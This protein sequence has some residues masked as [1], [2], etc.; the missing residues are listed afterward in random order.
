VKEPFE[1]ELKFFDPGPLLFS[2]LHLAANERL[3][4]TFIEGKSTAL[5]FESVRIDNEF[6]I[7]MPMSEIAGRM[8]VII[9]ANLLSIKTGGCGLLLG[10]AMGI[11]HG[12]VVILGGGTAGKNAALAGNGLGAHVI[13]LE[14]D[15]SK[16]KYLN[17]VL[18]KGISI[19]K[20]NSQNL[21]NCVK[22]ANILIGTVLI[23]NARAP[24]LVSREMVRTMTP[25]SVIVDI[26]IDQG[27]CIETSRPT[28]HDNPTFI[29][30]EIIHYCVTNMPGAYPQT[31]TEAL[32]ENL[33]PFLLNLISEEDLLISLKKND[34]LK[35]SVNVFKGN[36]AIKTIADEFDIEY[37]PIDELL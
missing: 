31:S 11:Y 18:P 29:D 5:A 20:S 36:V 12:Y 26:S 23:P 1:E 25:G 3:I 35:N 15:I 21:R 24:R 7:L 9:G 16:I 10:G 22:L 34:T 14:K 37:K 28:T 32:S 33:F 4:R 6:P 19:I 2:F 30:E 27:G 8:S 13:I 17:D